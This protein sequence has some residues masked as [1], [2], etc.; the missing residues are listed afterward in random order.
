MD[1]TGEQLTYL[2]GPT[3][4][5]RMDH[6]SPF[7]DELVFSMA[8][9]QLLGIG[10]DIPARATWIRMR[11]CVLN[12]IASHLLFLATNGMDRGAV[13]IMISGWREEVLRSFQTVTGLRMNHNFVRPGGVAA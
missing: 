4:A 2:Q 1:K 7:F 9:E 8:T 10:D 3:N 11:F 13:S 5:T 6:L 12:R